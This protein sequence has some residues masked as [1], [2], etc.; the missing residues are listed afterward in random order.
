MGPL[1]GLRAIEVGDLGE[2]AGKLLADAG[3]ELIRVEPPA[4]ARSR[5]QGPYVHDRPDLNA[6]LRFAYYNTNKRG[7][8]L[9]LAGA[10]AAPLWRRLVEGA[11]IVIDGSGP[12]VLDGL[13]RGY[14]SFGDCPRLIWCSLTP[15]GLDGPW[16]DW[17][18]I[19]LVQLALGGPMASTG[20]DDHA[21]PPIRPDGE[22]SLW[23]GGEYAVDAILAALYLRER[24]GAGQFIDVSLHEAVSATTEGAFPAWEYGGQISQRQTGRH[25]SPVPTQPWQYRGTD[26]DYIN[27]MGGG[28]PRT[29]RTLRALLDWMVEKDAA[30]DLTDPQYEQVLFRGPAVGGEARQH[31]LQVIGRFAQKLSTEEAYRRGQDLHL[32]WGKIRR[33]EE[34]LDDPHWQERGFFLEGELPGYEGTVR[35][36]GA[37]YR[38]TATPVELRRRAPLLGE[39]NHE[40]YAGELGLTTP[41]LIALSQLGVI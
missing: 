37:A 28:V 5:R 34:N 29:Q 31:M 26:G 10:D 41:E 38:F 25:A 4:G 20:Y 23:M 21:L 13:S 36:P 19:D 39:H 12:G 30:E 18:S 11:D 8:T 1:T 9:D 40:V 33:P 32:P 7:V 24:T 35:Y 17:A 6:S 2:V 16:R 22:H 15:F 27:L 14:A 3:V